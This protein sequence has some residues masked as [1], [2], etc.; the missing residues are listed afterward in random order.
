MI[1]EHATIS[2]N[3]PTAILGFDVSHPGKFHPV[4]RGDIARHF[5]KK[6]VKQ[7]FYIKTYIDFTNNFSFCT[8]A[9]G[10]SIPLKIMTKS[11]SE[12]MKNYRKFY[13][14]FITMN[15]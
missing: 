15:E 11:T 12:I 9:F 3:F 2:I 7:K 14:P 10:F 4:P 1:Y 5:R 6:I 8:K 13:M